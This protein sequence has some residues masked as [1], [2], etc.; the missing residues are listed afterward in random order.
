MGQDD[1]PALNLLGLAASTYETA[2]GALI[3]LDHD[4]INRPLQAGRSGLIVRAGGVL[5]G[6]V[7]LALR[8]AYAFTGRTPLRRAAAVCSL[9]GS[10][11]TRIGWVEAGKASAKDHAL[12]LEAKRDRSFG[13]TRS[14]PLASNYTEQSN[15]S[16]NEAR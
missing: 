2:Q 10:L 5:S 7:P 13:A 8:L 9:A 15:P 6:P 12:P 16:S 4:R 1:S 11:L 14:R 3:E